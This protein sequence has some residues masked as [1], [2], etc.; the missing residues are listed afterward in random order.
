VANVQGH[1]ENPNEATAHL[2]KYTQEEIA[3]LQ[4]GDLIADEDTVADIVRATSIQAKE[5]RL[6]CKN[7]QEIPVLISVSTLPK[8]F[9]GKVMICKDLSLY[10][11]VEELEY[12]GKMYHEIAVQTQ[13]PLS[14]AF[15]WVHALRD[16]S[17]D[18]P[19][20]ETFEKILR[21]LKK[22]EITYDRLALYDH[23]RGVLPFNPVLCRMSEIVSYIRSAFPASETDKIEFHLD[24]SLPYLKGD[25]FQLNFCFESILSY[26]LR[27]IPPK[28][29]IRFDVSVVNDAVVIQIIGLLPN[30]KDEARLPGQPSP[31]VSETLARM[32]LGS[33]VIERFIENHGGSMVRR[34]SDGYEQVFDI[35]LP[36]HREEALP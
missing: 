27:H 17:S 29:C 22:I 6:K 16:Q 36:A 28:K 30:P 23:A 26:L 33:D 4:L 34:M 25:L 14:L 15:S 13:T 8:E 1:L 19:A 12:L 5:V 32:A 11:R 31:V 2:L 35:T 24:E 21:Q 10:K 18:R 7:G 9:G 3:G 20:I